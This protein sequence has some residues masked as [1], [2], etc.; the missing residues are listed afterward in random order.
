MSALAAVPLPYLLTG[1]GVL[2]AIIGSGIAEAQ[3]AITSMQARAI[4]ARVSREVRS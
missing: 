3:T 4:R 2:M 1:L